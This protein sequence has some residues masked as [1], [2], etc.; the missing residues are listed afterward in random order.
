MQGHRH[1]HLLLSLTIT[2]AVLSGCGAGEIGIYRDTAPAV[3]PTAIAALPDDIEEAE[4]V[5]TNGAFGAEDLFLLEGAPTVLHVTNRDARDYRFWIVEDLVGTFPIAANAVT[6]IEFT[7]PNADVYEGQLL[8]AE[9]DEPLD[10]V[11][12]VVRTAGG[13]EP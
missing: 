12:V 2:L 7:T 1:R 11:R 10:T 6:D 13:V 8:A 3:S 4:L 5:V 9:G